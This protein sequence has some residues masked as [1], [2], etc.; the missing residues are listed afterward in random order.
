MVQG[1]TNDPQLRQRRWCSFSKALTW[2][3]VTSSP[4]KRSQVRA[5][6]LGAIRQAHATPEVAAVCT[7][8]H[9]LQIHLGG[10]LKGARPQPLK[11]PQI[12]N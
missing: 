1:P 10:L 12:R 2:C 5:Q 8:Q 11:A 7:G 4:E 3:Q 9:R 6:L